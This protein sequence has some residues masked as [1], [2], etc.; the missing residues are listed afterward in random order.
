MAFGDIYSWH[1]EAVSVSIFGGEPT[2]ARS[3]ADLFGAAFG[4]R[5]T[6]LN[7]SMQVHGRV[8]QAAAQDAGVTKVLVVQPGR[9]DVNIQGVETILAASAAPPTV[10]DVTQAIDLSVA[11]AKRL[12]QVVPDPIRLA[13][14]VRLVSHER[15]LRDA[16]KKILSVLPVKIPLDSQSDFLLQLNNPLKTE[17][18]SINRIV[19]W[20]V[21][22]IQ[23]ISATTI[24]SGFAPTQTFSQFFSAFT[25]LDFNTVA[26]HIPMEIAQATNSL[27]V[28]ASEVVKARRNSLR[29]K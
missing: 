5:C 1:A 26:S 3:L 29:F 21:E 19:K 4:M 27:D 10:A 23:L 17:G 18:V 28:L 2:G 13:L 20:S 15:N 6:Q 8:G 24:G 12:L 7:E 9:F 14:N 16:N 11:A 25:H 22:I